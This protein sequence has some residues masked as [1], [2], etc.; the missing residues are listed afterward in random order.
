M[1]SD[2]GHDGFLVETPTIGQLLA[3]FLA[4]QLTINEA[5][6]RAFTDGLGG[7]SFALPGSE[8]V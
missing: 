3:D 7:R 2:Y 4:D 1:Q 6:K 5:T 8:E